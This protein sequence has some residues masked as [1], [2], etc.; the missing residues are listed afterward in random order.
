MHYIASLPS[1]VN[2]NLHLSVK[3]IYQRRKTIFFI[4][5]ELFFVWMA[6]YT[7]I[8]LETKII[9][10]NMKIFL[11]KILILLL[12]FSSNSKKSRHSECLLF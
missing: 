3:T 7:G 10:C 5:C 11:N 4:N 8:D 9:F 6:V 12:K 1:I 2:L